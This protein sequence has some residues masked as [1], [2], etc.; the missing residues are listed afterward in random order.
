MTS[1]IDL[2][3]HHLVI[4]RRVR[5]TFSGPGFGWLAVRR[6]AVCSCGWSGDLHRDPPASDSLQPNALERARQDF[7]HHIQ[8]TNAMDM[9][10]QYP[11]TEVSR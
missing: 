2:S 7:N 5:L 1:S 6:Q 4:D 8:Y 11:S 3:P 10:S 9:Q